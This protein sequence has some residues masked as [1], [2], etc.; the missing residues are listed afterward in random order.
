MNSKSLEFS[1][2]RLNVPRLLHELKGFCSNCRGDI[3]FDRRTSLDEN[4]TSASYCRFEL[5]DLEKRLQVKPVREK[6]STK[7]SNVL[8]KSES[9]S[10]SSQ[11][12]YVYCTSGTQSRW[13]PTNLN[14]RWP[15]CSIGG[16][17]VCN[18]FCLNNNYI[19][20][21][22]LLFDIHTP[23]PLR[24]KLRTI[25][26]GLHSWGERVNSVLMYYKRR[27]TSIYHFGV[28]GI[29]RNDD[30]IIRNQCQFLMLSR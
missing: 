10:N 2:N 18:Y 13:I 4:I 8:Q 24:S 29:G 16:T 21:I 11:W 3:A 28:V 5:I 9:I 27:P 19:Y 23:P 7:T 15:I 20:N 14:I 1:I 25:V 17:K 22:M 6:Y 12:H 26:T 30:E